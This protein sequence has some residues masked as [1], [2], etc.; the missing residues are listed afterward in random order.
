MTPKGQIDTRAKT[1]AAGATVVVGSAHPTT[2][3][4]Y[5]ISAAHVIKGDLTAYELMEDPYRLYQDQFP[6]VTQFAVPQRLSAP[7]PDYSDVQS[8]MGAV[9]SELKKVNETLLGQQALLEKIFTIASNPP[10]GEIDI[11]EVESATAREKILS[12]F[13]ESGGPL[14]YDEIS[15]RLQLPLRQTVEICN[16]LEAEGLIGEPTAKQ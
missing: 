14:F 11:E 16:Q 9:L 12:L 13:N 8:V 4:F 7:T 15:E 6:V 1:F 5:D 2:S 10:R 3:Y